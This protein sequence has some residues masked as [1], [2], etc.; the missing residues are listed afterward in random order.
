[1]DKHW[2]RLRAETPHLK[3]PPSEYV[4]EHVWFTTQPI[5]EPEIPEHL[6]DIIGWIG[7]DRLMFST[8]YPHWDFDDP[9]QAFKARLTEPQKAMVFRD[10]AKAFYGL[11]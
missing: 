9:R 8:D 2:A 6:L 4:R 11:A 7:W 5:E 10:N 3:R 1:M